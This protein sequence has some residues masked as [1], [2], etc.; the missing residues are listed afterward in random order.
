MTK[1]A[2]PPA[3]TARK[4]ST[5]ASETP[6]PQSATKAARKTAANKGLAPVVS[7]QRAAQRAAG[8]AQ[9]HSGAAAEPS[10]R[11]HYPQPL[12]AKTHAVLEALEAAPERHG[13]GEAIAAVV[14]ELVEAGMD[15]YFMRALRQVDVGFVAEQTA[16]VG[17]SGAL[18]LINSMSRKYIVRMDSEQ[19]LIVAQH[20]R[21]LS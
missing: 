6:T 2:A 8:S 9:A 5:P 15:Y 1:I 14:S 18:K 17:L 3:R 11:F 19:L 20:I 21:Q 4:A 13:H 10:L 7:A 16:R 12:H